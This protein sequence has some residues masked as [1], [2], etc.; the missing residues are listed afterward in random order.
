[1]LAADDD[2]SVLQQEQRRRHVL[3]GMAVTA[4]SCFA[5]LST[6]PQ[7][8]NAL[9]KGVAP[10]PPKIKA[11]AGGDGDSS[12]SSSKPKCTNVEECQEIA[13][14]REQ[15]LREI[16]EEGPPPKTTAGGV[17]YRDME[18]DADAGAGGDGDGDG[19]G[20]VIKD[21]DEVFLYYKVLKLGKRS[22]D[23]LSGEGTVVFSKGA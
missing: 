20:A 9:V 23:G 22:Y 14:K 3:Q 18:D 4:G 19:D 21:E 16:Q 6:N 10:P 13:Y 7:I 5:L 2:G 15:E 11:S 12:S 8:S 1:M 17:R